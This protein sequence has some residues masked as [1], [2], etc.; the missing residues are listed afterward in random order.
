MR[1]LW[2]ATPGSGC[3]FMQH[4]KW[5]LARTLPL[6][7]IKQEKV[8]ARVSIGHRPFSFAHSKFVKLQNL[9]SCLYF[10]IINL[11]LSHIHCDLVKPCNAGLSIIYDSGETAL[12]AI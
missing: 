6:T 1:K 12:R 5:L 8:N 2:K 11:R 4:C 7:I 10:N 3:M 9:N